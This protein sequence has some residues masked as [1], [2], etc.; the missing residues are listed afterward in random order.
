MP[1][2]NWTEKVQKAVTDYSSLLRPVS[3]L[4]LFMLAY[5]F[6]LRPIQKQALAPG[7]PYQ[8]EQP[9]L[10][11]RRTGNRMRRRVSRDDRRDA[12]GDATERPDD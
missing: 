5:L 8:A 4:V 10:P 2:P 7:Q 1:A 3:L 12:A 9:A 6:V 11:A